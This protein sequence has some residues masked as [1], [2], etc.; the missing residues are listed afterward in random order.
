VAVIGADASTAPV[1]TGFGSSRSSPRSPRPRWTP[2][3][4]GS[5]R[6][7][8]RVTYTNGGSTT[9]NLPAVPTQ[10][11]TPASGGARAHPDPHRRD[12]RTGITRSANPSRRSCPPPTWPSAPTAPTNGLLP[13]IPATVPDRPLQPALAVLRRE[14]VSERRPPRSGPT[15]NSCRRMVGRGGHLDRDPHPSP[16][17]PLHRVAPGIGRLPASPSTD[18]LRCPTPSVH[19]RMAGGHRPCHSL[20]ATLPGRAGRGTRSTPDPFGRVVA[21]VRHLRP[22]LA[23]RERPDRRRGPG[24]PATAQRGRG[25]RRRLQLGGLRPPVAVAA[26]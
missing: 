7:R 22:G 3:A 23:V 5:S 1:T 17:R 18:R 9:R 15:S 16:D 19:A 12:P 24:R 21:R 11:L 4:T 14:C 13:G 6:H 10:L 2:S 25:L 20:V 26:R 8:H